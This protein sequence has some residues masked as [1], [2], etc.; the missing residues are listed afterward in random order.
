MDI[1][2]DLTMQVAARDG[3]V[4]LLFSRHHEA[5]NDLVPEKTDHMML[6]PQGAL[7]AAEC[8]SAMAFEADTGLKPVGEVLKVELVQKHR[9]KLAPRLALM[10]N[11]MRENKRITN[12]QLAKQM[13]DAFCSEVFS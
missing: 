12:Q 5:T 6:D 10:L 9:E 4:I 7:L 2:N 13:L 11:S 1:R 3:K 8:M